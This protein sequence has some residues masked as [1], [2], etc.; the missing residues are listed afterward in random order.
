MVKS[1]LGLAEL[2]G[3]DAADAFAIAITHAQSCRGIQ[4]NRARPI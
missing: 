3:P 4:S 2:P 1:L